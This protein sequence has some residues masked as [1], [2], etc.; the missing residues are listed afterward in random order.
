MNIRTG[1]FAAAVLLAAVTGA[2]AQSQA[3]KLK[4]T[5][6][7]KLEA[8]NAAPT[9]HK[10]LYENDHIRLLE[11]TIH[12]GEKEPMHGHKY[13]S[14]FAFDAPQPAMD[15][16]LLSGGTTHIGRTQMDTDFPAC[17][18][19][20]VQAPHSVKIT[21]TFQQHFYRLEFKHIDDKEILNKP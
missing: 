4:W 15:N 5:W 9:I 21:D 14:V 7:D 6:D 12:A 19:M 11:V 10:V 8:V 2:L 20:G 17:R 18:T 16:E 1:T 3:S 13:P